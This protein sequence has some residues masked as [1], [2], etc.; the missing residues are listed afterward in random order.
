MVSSNST[1]NNTRA[2]MPITK[3]LI[4]TR[5]SPRPSDQMADTVSPQVQEQECRK[6]A[7]SKGYRVV[8]VFN[9]A[10]VSRS[11]IEREGLVRCVQAVRK[12]MV[13]IVYHPD[14][15]GSTVPAAVATGE[16]ERKGGR[17]EYTLDALNGDGPMTELM[18]TI[19][20]AMAE[21]T[22][23]TGAL[24]TSA[25]MQRRQ[26]NGE[27][28]TSAARVPYGTMVDPNNPDATIPNPAE[29]KVIT[30]IMEM[31]EVE[32]LGYKPIAIRLENDGV[33]TRMGGQWQHSTV[34]NI[35]KRQLDQG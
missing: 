17:V 25:G 4:Y 35:V 21:F 7:Q 5:F 27:R 2:T 1:R 20:H 13:V 32:Q 33:P 24:K 3:A 10:G 15:L 34:R 28:M 9:D 30:R 29:V 31:Y 26:A 12:G 19:T 18:R 14:R 11:T 8:G 22:R 6:F 23:A 16:V